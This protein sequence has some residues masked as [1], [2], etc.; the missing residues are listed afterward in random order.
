MINSSSTCARCYRSPTRKLQPYKRTAQGIAS[1]EQ[2][3]TLSLQNVALESA[4]AT[5]T[6]YRRRFRNELLPPAV[7]GTYRSLL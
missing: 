6:Q 5:Y 7:A 2:D 3:V 4:I 1:G